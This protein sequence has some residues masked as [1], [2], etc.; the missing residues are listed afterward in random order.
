MAL[1]LPN[2]CLSQRECLCSICRDELG[3]RTSSIDAETARLYHCEGGCAL[4]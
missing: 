3:H 1:L 4:C 2:L